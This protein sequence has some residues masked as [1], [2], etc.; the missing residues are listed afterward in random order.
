[1]KKEKTNNKYNSRIITLNVSDIVTADWNYKQDATPEQLEILKA[2]ILKDGSCGVPAVRELISGQKTNYEVIDGNHRIVAIR[3]LGWDVIEVE[4]FGELS[5]AE[6]VLIARRRNEQWFEKD[7]V[8]L[9]NLYR[10]FVMPEYSLE[11]LALFMPPT[12]DIASLLSRTDFDWE[13][14]NIEHAMTEN[15]AKS[16]SSQ[17]KENFKHSVSD[18]VI[19]FEV[20]QN[21]DGEIMLIKQ[22]FEEKNIQYKIL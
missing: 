6:A 21:V 7:D 9:A 2:S 20:T 19:V 12:E 13:Q 14:F 5:M 10:D 3:E 22:F 18:N 1:M 8:K 4:N 16:L 15:P 17:S 11:A